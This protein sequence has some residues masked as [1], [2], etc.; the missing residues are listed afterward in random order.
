VVTRC[1]S[2]RPHLHI[3]PEARQ[4]LRRPF[5]PQ[6][7]AELLALRLV[8]PPLNALAFASLPRWARRMYGT[9]G[10]PLT[11]A[12]TNVALRAAYE[13]TGCRARC[14]TSRSWWPPAAVG[15]PAPGSV[16]TRPSGSG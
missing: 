6:M 10:I 13:S 2:F 16:R 7:P 5:T 1:R 4:A 14:C 9:P 15:A 12:A 3:T 8:L 11:D